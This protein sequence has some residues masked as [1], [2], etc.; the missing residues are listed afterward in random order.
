MENLLS[1]FVNGVLQEPGSSYTFEGGTTFDFNTPPDADDDISVFFYKGT[2]GGSN[3]DTRTKDV[4]ETLKTGDVVEIG[5]TQGDPVAQNPRTV[6]GI[7][8]SDTFETEIYTG[9]GI[10][11]TFKPVSSWRKQKI[12]K[13]IRGEVVS[14]SRNSLE[15][16][17]FPTSRI[18]GDL[19]TSESDSI[20]VDDAKFFNY[21]E[22]NSAFVINSIGVRIVNDVNPVSAALTATVSASGTISAITVVNGGSGYVGTTTSIL[23]GAPLGVA[24]TTAPAVAS[25]IATFA[26][27]TGN[28]SSGIITTVTV[29][30]IGLGYTSTNPPQVLAPAPEAIT[31][32]ITNIKDIQGFSGII[33]GIS[34]AVI[35]VSTL[36]LRIGLARTA[37]NFSTLQPGY[38]IYVFNT[39]VGNGVTSLNL[40]GA[41]GDIVGVGTQFADNIYMIQSIT[42]NASTAEILVNIHS[43]TAHVGLS[44]SVGTT[45]DRGNFSWGRLF[46]N[47]GNISRPDPVAIGVTGNTVGL[48][49]GVGISTFPTIERRIYG[50]RDTGAVKDK[51]T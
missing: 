25:G 16:L 41:D 50:I 34:T 35:G 48:S 22:D 11:L 2:S 1:I 44:T 15:P 30:N 9:P 8:T 38:P 45:G 7:T 49:T 29:N 19:S 6:V 12:D 51:L 43:G 27:A 26:T 32:K 4:P 37:G 31:E 21:E 5:A 23:I 18:I 13:I 24:A 20:F 40:S 33:T 17:I 10:G 14:K 3:P 42:K 39:T 46:T 47:T 28:I 36:G